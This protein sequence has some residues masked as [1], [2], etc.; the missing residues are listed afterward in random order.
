MQRSV[1]SNP[2]FHRPARKD[3]QAGEFKRWASEIVEWCRA[4]GIALALT[5]IDRTR[6][7][8]KIREI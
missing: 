8:C 7:I 4:S 2:S 3:A 1:T 5:K 6:S